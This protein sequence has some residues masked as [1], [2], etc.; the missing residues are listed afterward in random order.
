[1]YIYYIYVY[2]ELT[3]VSVGHSRALCPLYMASPLPLSLMCEDYELTNV[4]DKVQA[5]EG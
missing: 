3:L 1:M 5:V 2:S 4:N